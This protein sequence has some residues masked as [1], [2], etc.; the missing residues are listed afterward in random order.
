MHIYYKSVCTPSPNHC[1]LTAAC[2]LYCTALHWTSCVAGHFPA[3]KARL[4]KL[5]DDVSPKGLLVLSGDVHFAEIAGRGGGDG[6]DSAGPS[7]G[8]GDGNGGVG[9][10]NDV[11]EDDGHDQPKGSKTSSSSEDGSDGGEPG[12]G[13]DGSFG[14]I[15][16]TSS[17]MTHSCSTPWF[18]F[19]CVPVLSAFS[20]HRWR[21][22]GGYPHIN[23]GALELDWEKQEMHVQVKN[24]EG[25][26][27]LEAR[28]RI[29]VTEPVPL[30]SSGGSSSARVDGDTRG[31][32]V[33]AGIPSV[34]STPPHQ[35]SHTSGL[36]AW[37]V[38]IAAFLGGILA[39]IAFTNFNLKK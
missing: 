8:G 26:T 5:L 39:T 35:V 14:P 33:V 18:G 9:G 15:E 20:A 4:L 28:K 27:V 32:G 22:L 24:A 12:G 21:G 31:S 11:S 1:P 10:G 17:G 25:T 6:S 13:I 7:G 30:S 23:W 19:V 37:F 3:S 29:G 34:Y 36:H 16:V 38:Y 2:V